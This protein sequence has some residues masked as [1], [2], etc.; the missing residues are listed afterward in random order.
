MANLRKGQFTSFASVES[1][2]LA[3]K[4]SRQIPG[5]VVIAKA[6]KYHVIKGKK[7]ATNPKHRTVRKSNPRRTLIY[8]KI[9]RVE[10]TKGAGSHFAGQR[11]FHNFKKPY[12]KMYGLPDGSLLI[13]SK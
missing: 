3:Q 11:F 6:G 1:K 2:L 8:Q 5:S 9:T 13:T 12:P 10:G 7:I 4:I